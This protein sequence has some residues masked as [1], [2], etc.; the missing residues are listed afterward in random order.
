M[1]SLETR[2]ERPIRERAEPIPDD[3]AML[4]AAAEVTRD[5][6]TARPGVYWPDML[7]SAAV[8]Y[9]AL[10]GAILVDNTLLAIA[11]GVLA[12]DAGSYMPCSGGWVSA[13]SS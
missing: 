6:S 2:T 9:A 5:L 12:S 7:L 4:R 3:M 1:S 11:S 8:G 10:A 13:S